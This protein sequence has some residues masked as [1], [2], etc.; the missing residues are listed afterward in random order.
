MRNNEQDHMRDSLQRATEAVTGDPHADPFEVFPNPGEKERRAD[1][2]WGDDLNEVQQQGLRA[3][4]AELGPGRA[5]NIGPVEQGLTD[6][7]YVALTEGG[8]P[9]KMIAQINVLLESSERPATYIISGSPDRSLGEAERAIGADLLGIDS[10]EVADNELSMAEQIVRSYGE[11]FIPEETAD[12]EDTEDFT[13]KQIGSF[14]GRPVL[15]MGIK[16]MYGE[17]GGRYRQL[18]NDKKIQLAHQI[19]GQ[20][21]AFVTSATYAPS[22]TVSA[23]KSGV[24]ATVLSYG[25]HELAQVKGEEP[26]EPS[27]AQLGAEAYKTAKLLKNNT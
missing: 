9:H 21:V 27:I 13:L 18:S 25:T 3:A 1:I 20:T 19:N 7:N 14:N 15:L 22:N 26:A 2:V 6:G 23:E 11:E 8:Q 17:D 12:I 16:R 4:M 10:E 24:D 5:H